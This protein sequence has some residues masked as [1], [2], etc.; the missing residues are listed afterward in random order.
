[1]RRQG[2]KEG[3]GGVMNIIS[4]PFEH[5]NKEKCTW[6]KVTEDEYFER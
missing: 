3:G 5:R 2:N 4:R 6:Q 1:M